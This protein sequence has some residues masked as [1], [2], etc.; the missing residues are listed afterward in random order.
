LSEAELVAE[1]TAGRVA[2]R[3]FVRQLVERGMP[4]PDALAYAQRLVPE[5]VEQ[6]PAQDARETKGPRVMSSRPVQADDLEIAAVADGY[7]IINPRRQRVHSL[8]NTAL[9]LFE[10]CNGKN[11]ST[12]LA[13]LLQIAFALAAPPLAETQSCLEALFDEG[14]IV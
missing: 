12:E 2:R 11:D 4:L 14:L 5:A 6:A 3:A 1:F 8:N 9:V 13:R 7:T 10:L